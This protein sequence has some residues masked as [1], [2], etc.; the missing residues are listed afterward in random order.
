MC[1]TALLIYTLLDNNGQ[2]PIL[3]GIPRLTERTLKLF[4]CCFLEI[5]L[6][7]KLFRH[8]TLLSTTGSSLWICVPCLFVVFTNAYFPFEMN[9]IIFIE[10]GGTV[11]QC[12]DHKNKSKQFSIIAVN[13]RKRKLPHLSRKNTMKKNYVETETHQ[14]EQGVD[15]YCSIYTQSISSFDMGFKRETCSVDICSNWNLMKSFPIELR[16]HE[17][18]L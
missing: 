18:R 7:T 12:D 2:W 4:S 15:M 1:H 3:F 11:K 17:Q 9:N 6:Y 14:F 8:I 16:P 10:I 5:L 13:N